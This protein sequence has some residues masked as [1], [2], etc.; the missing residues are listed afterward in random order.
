MPHFINVMGERGGR[1]WGGREGD[2][3]LRVSFDY[4]EYQENVRVSQKYIIVSRIV[5][6]CVVSLLLFHILF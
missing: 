3:Y 2:F 5:N 6:N 1:G 4:Q